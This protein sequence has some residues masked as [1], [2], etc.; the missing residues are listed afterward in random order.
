MG[1]FPHLEFLFQQAQKKDVRKERA[2]APNAVISEERRWLH[3]GCR[4]S[5]TLRTCGV[6]LSTME[7]DLL[8]ACVSDPLE[9]DLLPPGCWELN[10]GPLEEQSVL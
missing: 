1:Q 5:R 9:L 10:P 7:T 8:P 4:E 3:G 6:K 2:E